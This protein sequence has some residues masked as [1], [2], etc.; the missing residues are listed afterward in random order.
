MS[1]DENKEEETQYNMNDQEVMLKDKDK[2]KLVRELVDTFNDRDEL[3]IAYKVKMKEII[4]M[5]ICE[6]IEYL[7]QDETKLD[8]DMVKWIDKFVEEKFRKENNE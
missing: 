5:A 6:F 4:L 1:D 8:L 3:H 7:N 2:E